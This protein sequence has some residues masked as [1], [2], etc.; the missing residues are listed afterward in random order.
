MDGYRLQKCWF[1]FASDNGRIVKPIHHAVMWWISEKANL[2]RWKSEFQLSTAEACEMLGISDRNTYQKAFKELIGFGAIKM[3]QEAKGTYSARFISF[4]GC[5]IYLL[6]IPVIQPIIDPVILP[7][8]HP[9]EVT[10]IIKQE[11]IE[12]LKQETIIVDKPQREKKSTV[13]VKPMPE[14]IFQYFV[15][16]HHCS[17]LAANEFTLKFYGFYES[18]GWKVGKNKMS[19][20][21]AAVSST[22]KDTAIEVIKKYSTEQPKRAYLNGKH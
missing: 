7:V 22:W 20:W 15:D 8:M 16:K 4:D 6:E 14:E 19:S 2:S 9:V 11:N 12:T 17:H 10:P 3:T 13:F 1:K 21:K 5:P 18:N